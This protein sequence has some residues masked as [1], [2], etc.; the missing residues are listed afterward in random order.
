MILYSPLFPLHCVY[1]CNADILF[2]YIPYNYPVTPCEIINHVM[3]VYMNKAH[4]ENVK[5]RYQISIHEEVPVDKVDLHLMLSNAIDNAIKHTDPD[6]KDVLVELTDINNKFFAGISSQITENIAPN[7]SEIMR[8][9][10]NRIHGYGLPTIIKTA[11]K[12]EGFCD[13]LIR[14]QRF[15]LVIDISY[16]GLK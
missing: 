9:D 13:Y 4:K 8:D 1:R 14:N 15:I 2:L 6:K 12:Y 10:K 11:E 5:L 3:F 7:R 16:T